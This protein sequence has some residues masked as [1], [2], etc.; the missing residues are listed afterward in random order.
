MNIEGDQVLEEICSYALHSKDF[1]VSAIENAYLC[2]WDALACLFHGVKSE[3]CRRRMTPLFD[4]PGTCVIPGTLLKAD[5]LNASYAISCAVRWLDYNDAW[6]AQEW[7]HPSDNLGGIL[8]CTQYMERIKG[9]KISG[10]KIL[11]WMIKAHEIQ[12]ILSLK[13][14]LNRFGLDHVA[15][16]RVASAAI[17]TSILGGGEREVMSALSNSFV[18]GAPLRIYRHAPATGWR[19]SWAAADAVR[20]A[21]WLAFMAIKGEMGYPNVL[22][23]PQWGFSDALLRGAPIVMERSLS[24][25]VMENVLFKPFPAEYHSQSAIEAALE[26]REEVLPKLEKIR[27]IEIHTQLPAIRII[28]KQGPLH[29]PAD[30]DHCLE[31]IVA[32]AL[33]YGRVTQ[34]LY[35][36]EVARDPRIDALRKRMVTIE[37]KAYTSEYYDPEKMAVPNAIQ[38]FFEDGTATIKKEILYPLGH[39]KRRSEFQKVLLQKIESSLDNLFSKER[40][41]LILDLY[42]SKEKFFSKSSSELVSLFVPDI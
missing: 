15:F 12:G 30:R 5:P 40:K 20:R 13:N 39:P 34:D 23:L 22:S 41:K 6:L 3:E 31:Y 24:Q 4:S 11:E 42:L 28:H 37:D 36:D 27:R 35:E 7:G 29:N 10:L 14:S 38:V 33:L 32:I 17:V 21:V 1:S 19:K 9:E 2:F 25:F 16:V 8:A 26:L 18:D